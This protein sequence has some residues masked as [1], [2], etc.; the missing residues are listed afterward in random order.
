MSE[1]PKRYLA[2]A[3]HELFYADVLSAS[4]ARGLNDGELA[5]IL[6]SILGRMLGTATGIDY[7]TIRDT[8]I[9]NLR[10]GREDVPELLAEVAA[11]R[12]N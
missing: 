9:Y 2:E 5:A 12:Q 10:N 8:I 3:K 11:R 7:T 6:A 1:I 4:A